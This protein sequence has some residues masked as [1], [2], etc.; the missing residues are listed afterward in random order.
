MSGLSDLLVG[1]AE[2]T[3]QGGTQQQ[4]QR[5]TA[6]PQE[7][8]LSDLLNR[9]MVGQIVAPPNTAIA[10]PLQQAVSS[11]QQMMPGLQQAASGSLAARLSGPAPGSGVT[12][13]GVGGASQDWTPGAGANQAGLQTREQL[14][15]PDRSSYFTFMPTAQQVADIGL[16]PV[17]PGGSAEVQKQFQKIQR[18]GAQ[19]AAKA[20]RQATPAG[21]GRK[22][23]VAQAKLK[24]RQGPSYL[25]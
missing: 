4:F 20:A 19:Q 17:R 2:A 15:L 3:K 7:Q 11:Y 25:R 13:T 18:V 14:G 6:P 9:A 24:A 10:T 21:P 8:Q 1:K 16:A 23:A 5:T 12:G 22:V